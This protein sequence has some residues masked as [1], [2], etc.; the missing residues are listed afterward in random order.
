VTIAGERLRLVHAKDEGKPVVYRS[1]LVVAEMT[2]MLAEVTSINRTD[3]LAE[4][5][6]PLATE[7]DLG[8][9]ARCRG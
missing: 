7:I 2:D 1:Q 9:E 8:M 4:H 5:L 6:C 3:H